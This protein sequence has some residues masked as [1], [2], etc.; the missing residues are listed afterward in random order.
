M[1]QRDKRRFWRKCR[2]AFRRFRICIW[3]LILVF[4]ALIL[5]FNQVGLPE[6]AK[7]SLQEKLRARGVD[8]E[9]TRMRWRWGQG[10]VA[11]NVQFGRAGDAATPHLSVREARLL[12]DYRALARMRVQVLGLDLRDGE[13]T[14]T[15]TATNE[16]PQE[17][18]VQNIQTQLRLL[19]GD[20]WELND[21]RAEFAGADI[22]LGG[23]ITNGSALREWKVMRRDE[24]SPAGTLERR[25]QRLADTLDQIHFSAQPELHMDVRGDAREP[26][27]FT[28]RLN[29]NTPGAETPWGSI[30]NGFLA[31]AILP[32]SSNMVSAAEARLEAARADTPWATGENVVVTVQFRSRAQTNFTVD[33]NLTLRAA[34]LQTRIGEA[35]EIELSAQWTHAMTNAIPLN[36]RG[37]LRVTR[38]STLWGAASELH[39]ISRLVESRAGDAAGDPSWAWWSLL[40]PHALDLEC[41]VTH[42]E[43]P[44]LSADNISL[45]GTWRAPHLTVSNLSARLYRGTVDAAANLDVATRQFDK[46]T[47]A[48][49]EVVHSPQNLLHDPH[50]QE[51]LP[52]PPSIGQRY[53]AAT[54][55]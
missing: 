37:E 5:Y 47:D 20:L 54:R 18:L 24:P 23:V 43:N 42:L 22:R 7:Q 38:P 11:E 39:L 17:L 33:A 6:I 12:I 19:P 50:G 30:Q 32:D 35:P 52:V 13:A 21:F 48:L 46:A 41:N 3:A 1:A 9:F 28:V 29:V 49:K 26:Q 14:W 40:A 31:L 15:V 10:I 51:Y 44:K 4:L 45:T 36:G 2:I 55:V 16:E 27:S 34:N 53:Q 8:F 25:L